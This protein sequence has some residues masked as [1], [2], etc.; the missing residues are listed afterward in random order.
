METERSLARNILPSTDHIRH[1]L[2]HTKNLIYGKLL[3]I[4]SPVTLSVLIFSIMADKSPAEWNSFLKDK[5]K[6]SRSIVNPLNA[7]VPPPKPPAYMPV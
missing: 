3:R 7:K 5:I 4:Y 1:L 6:D 2:A